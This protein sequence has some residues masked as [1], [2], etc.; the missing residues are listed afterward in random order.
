VNKSGPTSYPEIPG[1]SSSVIRGQ[2]NRYWE[3]IMVSSTN[4]GGA[5]QGGFGT[6]VQHNR[7][8]DRKNIDQPWGSIPPQ[9]VVPYALSYTAPSS[10]QVWFYNDE[11]FFEIAKYTG[12]ST[13]AN[14]GMAIARLMRDKFLALGP[15]AVQGIFYF[16]WTL[17]AAFRWTGDPSYKEAVASIADKGNN[18]R[19]DTRDLFAR[20]H[21]F[22][23]ERRLA[24][25]EVT[26]EEDYN[27]QNFADAA[28]GMLYVN[29][30]Q[31]AERTFNEPFITGL[32]M[33]PLIRWYMVSHDERVPAVIKMTLDTLWDK[34]YDKSTHRLLYN[35]D[36]PGVRCWGN[37]CGTTTG[38]GL[39]NLVSPA[40]AWYWRLTGDDIYRER[41]D[42]LFAHVWA[43]GNPYFAKEWSQGFYWSWDFVRWRKGVQ[44][45]H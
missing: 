40:F 13:W 5:S 16:P 30:A 11:T 34:W 32:L 42:D 15:T 24:R 20:E 17:V 44:P 45:A 18:F 7:C 26:G 3:N 43:D 8:A 19:G 25:R 21:A 33:R 38:T 14:C 2:P 37:G 4:G 9:N 39:N 22:A 28:I 23:F 41:G 35:T 36:P 6:G 27:L 10:T 29:A 1:F 31:S 12:D